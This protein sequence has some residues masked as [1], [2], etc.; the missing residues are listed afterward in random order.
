MRW[1][2]VAVLASLAAFEPNLVAQDLTV[3]KITIESSW[4]GLD[5][6]SSA[7]LKFK[8]KKGLLAFKGSA[9]PGERIVA[10]LKALQSQSLTMEES[11]DVGITQQ[12][13][14]QHGKTW[15]QDY[16][17]DDPE[18]AELFIARFTDREYM[19]KMYRYLRSR[20]HLDNDRALLLTITFSDGTTWSARSYSS[21]DYMLPWR[22][23][24][25]DVEFRTYNAA[26][27]VAIAELMPPDTLNRWL[28]AG[29]EFIDNLGVAIQ[30]HNLAEEDPHLGSASH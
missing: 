19:R 29:E 5:A 26:L 17:G 11:F 12:W 21:D 24:T 6:S 22:V 2:L 15:G 23:A 8:T 10:L 18:Y 28:L 25:G 16:E 14:D 30:L 9:I 1:R 27:S 3:S 20:I 4:E 7:N 13:L